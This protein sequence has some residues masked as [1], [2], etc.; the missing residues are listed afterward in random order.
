MEHQIALT[1]PSAPSVLIGLAFGRGKPDFSERE[2]TLLNL[3]RPHLIQAYRSAEVLTRREQEL[4]RLRQGLEALPCGLIVLAHDGGVRLWPEQARR[5]LAEYFGRS[6]RQT[7]RL[8]DSLHRWVGQ[9]CVALRQD[10]NI[11]PPRQP[12]CVER[13]GKR[14]VVRL[15]SDEAGAEDVLVLE[16]QRAAGTAKLL[17]PLGVSLREGE[18]LWGGGQGETK[19]AIAPHL[20]ISARTVGEQLEHVYQK[21]CVEP[22]T[23]AIVRAFEA[24]GLSANPYQLSQNLLARK[25]G[26]PRTQE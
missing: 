19:S 25:S 20:A 16:E 13:E 15:I 11:P 18:G 17:E 14:L 22:R 23:A 5:G 6:A 10:D 2:R 3:L 4:A 1:L 7:Q 12:L 24:L 21:L 9:Q 8:P 26:F